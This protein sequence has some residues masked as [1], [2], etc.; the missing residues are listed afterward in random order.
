MSDQ[1]LL[2]SGIA[3]VKIGPGDS[4][5]SHTPDEYIG[6]EE[7]QQGIHTTIELCERYLGVRT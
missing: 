4:A 6:I 3:S 7:L 2:P 5:R 1:S